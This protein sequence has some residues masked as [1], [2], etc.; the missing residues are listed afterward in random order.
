MISTLLRLWALGSGLLGALATS[1][2]EPR[3]QSPEPGGRAACW[4]HPPVQSSKG[5]FM[6]RSSRFLA[7]ALSLLFCTASF[8]AD[9]LTDADRAKLLAHL[10]KTSGAFLASV[11]G[12]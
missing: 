1:P 2:Q 5:G 10:D 4:Y 6:K 8:A 12:L 3:A 11:D 7:T 9:A